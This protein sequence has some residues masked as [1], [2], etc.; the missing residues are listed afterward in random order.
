M[1]PSQQ[2]GPPIQGSRLV[3]DDK[4]LLSNL[5]LKGYMSQSARLSLDE[6]FN[7]K[8]FPLHPGP[9]ILISSAIL[10]VHILHTIVN[11]TYYSISVYFTTV[12]FSSKD[13]R[14]RY[15]FSIE[16]ISRGAEQL[17]IAPSRVGDPVSLQGRS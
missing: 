6:T 9:L 15:D 10:N 8:L 12:P 3:G 11:K 13:L 5:R 7:L 2:N 1:I 4:F 16:K 14:S 17:Y